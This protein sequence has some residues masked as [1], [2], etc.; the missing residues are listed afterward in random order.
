MAKEKTVKY[1][2][3]MVARLREVYDPSAD[4]DER[5]SQVAAL[6]LELGKVQS[7][8]IGKL[9]SMGLYVPLQ[10]VPKTGKATKD[11]LVTR[12]EDL[13]GVHNGL[14]ESFA[15]ANKTALRLAT[16]ALTDLLAEEK[17]TTTNE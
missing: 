16:D 9:Y 1:T 17:E 6:A 13:L 2:D 4:Q 14:L 3:E 8:I 12:L 7:S 5:R 15:K 11:D 10:Y